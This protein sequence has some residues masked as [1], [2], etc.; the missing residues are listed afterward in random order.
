MHRRSFLFL[1]LMSQVFVFAGCGQATPDGSSQAP[2][3]DVRI[4]LVAAGIAFDRA[5]VSVQADRAFRVVLDN[6]D[7]GVPHGMTVMGG[8]GLTTEVIAS[9]IVTGPSEV[10]LQLPTGLVA[11]AYQII[12]P[13]HPVTMVA[14][15]VVTP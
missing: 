1:A 6:R 3:A 4:D 13:V 8:P 2:A 14:D 11:G 9:E 15:L 5:E 10:G 7:E 12:C